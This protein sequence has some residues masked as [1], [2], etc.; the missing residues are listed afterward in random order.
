[1]N[2]NPSDHDDIF[3]HL[4]AA[5]DAGGTDAMFETLAASLT[6]RRRWHA[7]FDL[8]LLETRISLGLPATG[9]LTG[10]PTGALG[11][12]LPAQRDEL[13][14][15]SLAACR[16]VGWPLL[17]EGQVAAAW[18]YLRAAATPADVARKLATLAEG[19]L[20][21]PGV[22]D[23]EDASARLQEIV[24]VALWEGVDPALGISLVLRT[25]GTCNAITAYEQAVSRLPARRQEAAAGVLVR[26]LHREVAAA[27]TADLAD[28]GATVV[29]ANAAMPAMPAIPSM[30]PLLERL[31][32][33]G[34]A[35]D[36]SIHVDVSHLQ[37][38]LRIARV[39]TD[40]DVIREA[41]ELACY[42]CRLPA[43]MVYP[44]EP[45]FENVGESSRQFFG[46]LL[47]H[48]VDRAV[49]FFRRAAARARIEESGTLPA[50]TLV[51]L[52]T[53][54]GRP[55]EA[56]HAA[57]ERPAEGPM[58]S[59]MLASGMLPS[60]VELAAAADSWDALLTAC[61]TRG[62]EITYAATLAARQRAHQSR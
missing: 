38:V 22:F 8:R 35:D 5:A 49:G 19:L 10:S 16:E 34:G 28:R 56:L 39:C 42:A 60:L 45:P 14:E 62:D 18:M 13:D 54:L 52:L 51:L 27:L 43:E 48:D 55:T 57:L 24:H 26:H 7:L 11:D 4:A 53:R 23:D 12:V 20:A 37:S 47:G 2:D 30:L 25:Q 32:E 1:M 29:D 17:D 3:A 59:A 46:P 36:A 50:D 58:P 44:G 33:V 21:A 40:P 31:R 6:G 9:D 41:W 15:R 61:Q